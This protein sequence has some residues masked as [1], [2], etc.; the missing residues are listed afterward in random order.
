MRYAGGAV[1]VT[2][3]P[4]AGFTALPLDVLPVIEPLTLVAVVLLIVVLLTVELL[5]P[6]LLLP[7]AGVETVEEFRLTVLL[8]PAPPLSEVLFPLEVSLCE[9]V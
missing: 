1:L 2:L 5:F 4:V 8:T 7:V 6:R 3:E 9:P